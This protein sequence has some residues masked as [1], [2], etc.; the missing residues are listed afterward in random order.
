M[1]AKHAHLTGDLPLDV[2]TGEVVADNTESER[3]V[4]VRELRRSATASPS[5][6]TDT[7]SGD[8]RSSTVTTPCELGLCIPGNRA[9]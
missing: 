1:L 4:P 8:W 3:Y 7:L 9:L 5:W 6:A 2:A